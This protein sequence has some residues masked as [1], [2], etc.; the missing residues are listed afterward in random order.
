MTTWTGPCRFCGTTLTGT[1]A[2]AY[3]SRVCHDQHKWYGV[4][5]DSR[6]SYAARNARRRT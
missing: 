4:V 2:R 1:T 5:P 6:R 3:C